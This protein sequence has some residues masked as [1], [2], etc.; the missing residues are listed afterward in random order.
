MLDIPETTEILIL[1]L[2][3]WSLTW[4]FFQ[5][6]LRSKLEAEPYSLQLTFV[7]LSYL[8]CK[9]KKIHELLRPTS[10]LNNQKSNKFFQVKNLLG[11]G[12][13]W[14]YREG[15]HTKKSKRKG[16]SHFRRQWV[17]NRIHK[18]GSRGFCLLLFPC[19]IFIPQTKAWYIEKKKP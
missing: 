17:F 3:F 16:I 5:L 15:Y 12:K 2:L 10:N 6:T 1:F 8:I 14:G 4:F 9:K 11:L 13:T 19:Y 18:S 7:K